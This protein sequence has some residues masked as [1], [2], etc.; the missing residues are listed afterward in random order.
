QIEDKEKTMNI[1][2]GDKPQSRV[3][4][5]T[6]RA[7]RALKKKALERLSMI[8]QCSMQCGDSQDGSKITILGPYRNRDKWRLVVIDGA[9]RKSVCAPSRELALALKDKLT[10][11]NERSKSQTVGV[12]LAQYRVYLCN[13]RGQLPKTADHVHD[14]LA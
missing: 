6:R 10:R 14:C 2:I 13:V 5:I 8:P 11:E 9:E 1:A 12:L 4:Q 3:N 7:K